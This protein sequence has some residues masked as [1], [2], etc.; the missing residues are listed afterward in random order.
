[1]LEG[2]AAAA[3]SIPPS[4]VVLQYEGGGSDRCRLAKSV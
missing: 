3:L 1:M 2:K 4:L